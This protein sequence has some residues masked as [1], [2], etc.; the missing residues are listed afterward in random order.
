MDDLDRVIWWLVV[1]FFMVVSFLLVAGC[2]LHTTLS[3]D[4]LTFSITRAPTVY[5]SELF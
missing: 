2:T 4:G 1:L 5:H 3:N